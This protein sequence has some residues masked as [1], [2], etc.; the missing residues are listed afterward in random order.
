MPARLS[1][2]AAII[3]TL[4]SGYLSWQTRSK[5]NGLKGDLAAAQTQATTA[6]SKVADA[7]KSAK[8]AKEA[9]ENAAKDKEA[10]E[11]ALTTAKSD[12][13]KAKAD[14]TSAK[15]DVDAKQKEIDDLKA[16]IAAAPTPA[17]GPDPALDEMKK[18]LAD[19]DAKM[20][21]QQQVVESLQKK[22]T[23]TEQHAQQLEQEEARRKTAV[24]LPGLEGK[25]V[26]VNPSWNFVVLNV[27]DRQGI[28][29]NSTLVVKR[30]GNSV[31]RLRVTSVEPATSIAD[32]VPGTVPK[33]TYV[34][35]GDVAIVPRS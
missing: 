35:P 3:L 21:E 20:K 4:V 9:A 13:D 23:E 7:A 18:Q 27:G 22:Q 8:E 11:T 10:A 1:I 5:V 24:S 31:A 30:G 34:Q 26:A 33:G 25:V 12:A 14:L 19:A 2:I 28:V 29:M 32:I 6:E 15:A 16:K 17:P